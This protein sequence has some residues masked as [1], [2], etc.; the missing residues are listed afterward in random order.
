MAE[1]NGIGNVEQAKYKAATRVG[2]DVV[3]SDVRSELDQARAGSQKAEDVSINQHPH[4][5][6]A[7]SGNLITS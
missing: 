3:R 4:P 2:T 7:R 6:V 5:T 1:K